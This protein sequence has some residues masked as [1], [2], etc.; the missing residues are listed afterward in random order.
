MAEALRCSPEVST[1]LLMGSIPMMGQM[2]KNLPAMQE[3]L[4]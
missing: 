2:V 3:S 4:V 1:A